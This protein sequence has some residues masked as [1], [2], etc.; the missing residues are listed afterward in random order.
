L[1][2]SGASLQRLTTSLENKELALVLATR[3]RVLDRVRERLHMTNANNAN[4]QGE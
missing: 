4:N 3:P 2:V 1:C